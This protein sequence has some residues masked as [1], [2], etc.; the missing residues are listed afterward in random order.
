MA[1]KPKSGHAYT[2][3]GVKTFARQYGLK[4]S[5]KPGDSPLISGGDWFEV[6]DTW[7]DAARFLINARNDHIDLSKPYPWATSKSAGGPLDG[8]EPFGPR[9]HN[10]SARGSKMATAKQIA[11]R[12]AFS[13]IMKS[14][15]FPKKN[16]IA[17]KS[18]SPAHRTLTAKRAVM[19]SRALKGKANPAKRIPAASRAI[20]PASRAPSA[21]YVHRIKTTGERGLLVA[22]F[23]K[24]SE[25]V[26][27]ATDYASTHNVQVGIVGKK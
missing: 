1:T 18:K 12:K 9:S 10:P 6:F 27:F 13:K 15:G 26:Q 2:V 16:P 8:F 7:E 4:I 23:T 19:S 11:A 20:N 5:P 25:A 22:I 24:K 21:Y 14:G 17:G 3:S